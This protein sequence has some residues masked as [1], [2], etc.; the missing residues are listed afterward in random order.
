MGYIVVLMILEGGY[1]LFGVLYEGLG[2]ILKGYSKRYFWNG[3][4]LD[5]FFKIIMEIKVDVVLNFVVVYDFFEGEKMR[6]L[7][8][9]G[10]ME[11]N[12]IVL[13]NMVNSILECLFYI[14]IVYVF[15]FYVFM[16]ISLV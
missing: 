13:I 3:R 8:D 10:M 11:V 5:D 1:S 14:K 2:I 16:L 7:F 15:S 6:W 4:D 12:F 9:V